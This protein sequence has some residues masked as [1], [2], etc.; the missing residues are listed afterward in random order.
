VQQVVGYFLQSSGAGLFLELK[1]NLG[2]QHLLAI[3]L[4]VSAAITS[5][6]IF[7]QSVS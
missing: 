4:K 2:L 5:Y 1:R 6:A 7:A 3:L